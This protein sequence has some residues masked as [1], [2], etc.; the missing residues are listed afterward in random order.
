M[1]NIRVKLRKTED[2]SYDIVIEEGVLKQIPSKIKKAGLGHRFAI[3]TDSTVESLYGTQLSEEFIKNN[4]ANLK[5]G[6]TFEK[7]FIETIITNH[8]ILIHQSND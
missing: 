4:L 3:I 6:M 7:S 5:P 8:V 1:E 2:K